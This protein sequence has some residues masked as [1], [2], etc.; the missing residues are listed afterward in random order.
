RREAT[1]SVG[2]MAAQTLVIPTDA[3]ALQ[4][5]GRLND[6]KK[7]EFAQIDSRT[8]AALAVSGDRLFAAF[9]TDDPNL[10]RN[11]PETL[12]NT[13]KTGGALDLM[14]EAIPGGV[15]LLVTRSDDKTIA[16]LY[17]PRVPGTTTEPVK[18]ASNIGAPK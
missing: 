12:Q 5:D 17:R 15:R 2:G 10:L 1:P 9:K 8:K 13:F 16:M 6:W 4:V 14:L 3:A 7:V 18:F 11:R